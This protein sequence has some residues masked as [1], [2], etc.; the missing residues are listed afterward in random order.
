MAEMKAN[1]DEWKEKFETGWNLVYHN[2]P[3]MHNFLDDHRRESGFVGNKS[4]EIN[5][6]GNAQKEF[7]Q[8]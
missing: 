3:Q 8:M 5:P 2:Y 7:I 4:F 6:L 1:M